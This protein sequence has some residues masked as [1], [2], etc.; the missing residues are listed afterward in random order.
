MILAELLICAE[1]SDA[2][3]K[4][5]EFAGLLEAMEKFALNSG[6]IITNGQTGTETVIY[7]GKEYTVTTIPAWHWLLGVSSY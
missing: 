5:R 3:T 7:N 4:Q 2:A 6:I 1:L